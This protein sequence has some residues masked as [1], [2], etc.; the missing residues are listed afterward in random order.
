MS[1]LMLATSQTSTV[2][3]WTG[4]IAVV[5]MV[6][7]G[8][9]PS[10]RADDGYGVGGHSG[11]H[12]GSGTGISYGFGYPAMG[13]SGHGSSNF[14]VGPSLG[15]SYFGVGPSLNY[16][17]FG[18]GPS[19]NYSNFGVSPSLRYSNL[20]YSNLG[21]SNFGY[22][23]RLPYVAPTYDYSS[24]RALGGSYQTPSAHPYLAPRYSSMNAPL[25]PRV[26]MNADGTPAGELRPGMILPDGAIVVSVG[27]AVAQPASNR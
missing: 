21:Y 23:P 13:N 17:N 22:V 25:P 4:S 16:S 27:Q 10:L 12:L 7:L 2:I 9:R 19:L 3:R 1:I 5:A 26:A 14:G 20:G 6:V 15:F 11:G 24:S 8:L 18:V